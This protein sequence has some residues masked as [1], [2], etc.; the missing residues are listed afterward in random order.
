LWTEQVVHVPAIAR[1]AAPGALFDPSGPY[2][3]VPTVAHVLVVM[4]LN[5]LYRAVALRL[6]EAEN[7]ATDAA[8]ANSLVLKRFLFEAFDCYI[9]L[10]YLAFVQFDVLRLRSELV[11]LYTADTFRR[12][13]TEA[14]LPMLLHKVAMLQLR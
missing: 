11:A 5:G 3:L 14:V 13:G 1:W 4:Q 2:A 6:T 9:P 7:H 8:F 12:I 10:V